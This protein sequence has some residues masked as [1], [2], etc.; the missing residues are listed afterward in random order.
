MIRIPALLPGLKPRSKRMRRPTA[1][2]FV[3]MVLGSLG[4]LNAE[5]GRASNAVLGYSRAADGSLTDLPGS[6]FHTGGT[7]YR[8]V[9]ERIGP[10]DSDGELIISPGSPL[11]LCHQHG[12]Q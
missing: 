7:G 2:C 6:A 3:F 11:S 4:M 10:D 5:T 8:N 12:K 9:N 1:L